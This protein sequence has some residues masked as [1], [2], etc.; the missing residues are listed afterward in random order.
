[1]SDKPLPPTDKRVRDA[2]A[3]GNVARS[4][5]WAGFVGCLLATEAAF[6]MID[7]GIDRWLALQ[8]AVFAALAEAE[9][10]LFQVGL[11]LLPDCVGAIVVIIGSFTAVALG[12]AVLA[13][14]AGGGL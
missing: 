2:A 7:A 5:V 4:D 3:D 1:M 14:W 6:A 11:R 10:D 9:A 8:A 12:A 13:A